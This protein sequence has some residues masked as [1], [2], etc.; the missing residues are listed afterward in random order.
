MPDAGAIGSED[1]ELYLENIRRFTSDK[2]IPAERR[3][4]EEDA[5]P[6]Q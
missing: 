4:E 1:F 3:V 5:V 2:L 6:E